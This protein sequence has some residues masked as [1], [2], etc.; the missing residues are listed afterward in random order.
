MWKFYVSVLYSKRNNF[1][2]RFSSLIHQLFSNYL[3]IHILFYIVYQLLLSG[4]YNVLVYFFNDT[5]I[6]NSK[7]TL[8]VTLT[9]LYRC[10]DFNEVDSGDPLIFEKKK[11]YHDNQQTKASIIT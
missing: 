8:S 1:L 3:S 9:W 7:L 11:L 10:I 4:S 5:N 2:I 6:V